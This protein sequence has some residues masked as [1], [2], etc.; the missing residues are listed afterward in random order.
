MLAHKEFRFL[1][2]IMPFSM[3]ISAFGL[4]YFEENFSQHTNVGFN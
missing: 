4:Q 2:Q 3:I 1:N